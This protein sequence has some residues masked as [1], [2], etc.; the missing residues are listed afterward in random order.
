MLW[1]NAFFVFCYS[2]CLNSLIDT[3]YMCTYRY[4]YVTLYEHMYIH[5]CKY[6]LKLLVFKGWAGD[7]R[8]NTSHGTK[9]TSIETCHTRHSWLPDLLHYFTCT[10]LIYC[11][12]ILYTMCV[13]FIIGKDIQ[14]WY[15]T[16]SP[17]FYYW[18]GS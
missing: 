7:V 4:I 6:I 11:L 15:C 12:F 16:F 2:F 18:W 1:L 9:E 17:L 10:Y 8:T 13:L 14:F 3:T 5:I